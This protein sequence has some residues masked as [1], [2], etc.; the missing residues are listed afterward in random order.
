MVSKVFLVVQGC[1]RRFPGYVSYV[2]TILLLIVAMACCAGNNVFWIVARPLLCC[3][4]GIL[5]VAKVFLC[6]LAIPS[7]KKVYTQ[8][9]DMAQVY[10]IVSAGEYCKSNSLEKK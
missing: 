10:R 9:L 1:L 8:V 3:F 7:H 5:L 2:V 4:F 6:S